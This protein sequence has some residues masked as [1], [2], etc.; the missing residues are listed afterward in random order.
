[1]HTSGGKQRLFF[2]PPQI[3]DL[4]TNILNKTNIS[5]KGK[6]VEELKLKWT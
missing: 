3:C 1:M 2:F 6:D 4:E 5:T